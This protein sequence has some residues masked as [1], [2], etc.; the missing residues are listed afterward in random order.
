MKVLFSPVGGTDPIS[1]NNWH[2][3]AMLHICRELQPDRVVLYMSNEILKNH[4]E[5]N[6]YLYC[7]EKLAEQQHRKMEYRII[8]RPD[9]RNVQE[10][11]FFYREFREIIES[12]IRELTDQDELLLNISSGT[13]AMKSGIAVLNTL[14]EYPCKLVQVLTPARGMNEHSH[15]GYD[16]ETLWECDEDNNPEHENRCKILNGLPNLSKIKKEEMMKKHIESFDYAA[17][18]TVARTMTKPDRAS[19]YPLL[20]AA[21]ARL[22][23]DRYG[24]KK[25]LDGSKNP[26]FQREVDIARGLSDDWDLQNCFEYALSLQVKLQKEEYADFIRGITPLLVEVFRL[27]LL[28][29]CDLDIRPYL[30]E[31]RDEWDEGALQGTQVD[32]ILKDA[33]QGFHYGYLYSAHLNELIQRLAKNE[34]L[35]ELSSN[36]RKFERDIR[37]MAAHQIITITDLDIRKKTGGFSAW[38]IMKMIQ[39]LFDYT[40]G[41]IKPEDWKSYNRMNEEIIRS[42]QYEKSGKK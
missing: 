35:K 37:N 21:Q 4:R 36:L 31:G 2:D 39:E 40:G 5:D 12:I 26:R 32:I 11:D 29:E 27:A 10:F 20:E 34:R 9:L 13:P 3:G 38:Q 22:L 41:S 19:Y 14:E 33:Y 8:E 24:V 15:N 23:L 30:K 25:A 17:A 16:V 7:L 18:L 1:M 28:S 6:R 42:M